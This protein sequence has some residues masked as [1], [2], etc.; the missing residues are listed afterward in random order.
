MLIYISHWNGADGW[1][2]TFHPDN[3]NNDK[4]HLM[5]I[6][7][8][9]ILKL[10]AKHMSECYVWVD[11]SCINQNTNPARALKQLDRIV[12]FCDLMLTPLVDNSWSDWE[13]VDTEKGWTT[14][15]W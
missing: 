5:I 3:S 15:R 7:I 6:A 12:Q 11:F 1:D 9:H 8:D 10:F 4:Y 14:D 2:G 13:L